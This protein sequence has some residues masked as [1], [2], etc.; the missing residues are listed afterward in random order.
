MTVV[1]EKGQGVSSH[2]AE[3]HYFGLLR[4]GRRGIDHSEDGA[5][6]AELF[7]LNSTVGAGAILAELG[8]GM[9]RFG[10]V[11]PGDGDGSVV[12]D[13]DS[14]RSGHGLSV[15]PCPAKS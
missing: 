5:R 7:P 3:F 4:G 9:L 10:A 2:R 11:H 12:V 8:H 1:E 15:C 14:F 13:I 6:L